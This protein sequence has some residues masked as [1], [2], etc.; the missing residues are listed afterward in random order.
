MKPPAPII[1]KLVHIHGPLKGTIQEFSGPEISIG[2]HPSCDIS[3]PKD[4]VVLSRRHARIIR[5]GNRFKIID[6]SINGTYV[7]KDRV[8]DAFLKNGDVITLT[9]GGPK[10]SFLTQVGE[11]IEMHTAPPSIS[12]APPAPPPPSNP[13]VDN[14]VSAPENP[15]TPV[16]SP[17][18][19]V[20]LSVPPTPDPVPS[21]QIQR[22]KAPLVIQ[23]GAI[24][25][26]F[27]ELPV[28]IGTDASCDLTL[29]H[30]SLAPKHVQFAFIDGQYMVKDLSGRDML[31]VNGR[32]V[33]SI[34]PIAPEDTIAFTPDG[35]AFQFMA[36][37]R[38]A[39]I[40]TTPDIEPAASDS[41]ETATKQ[42]TPKKKR[43]SLLKSIFS[44][45]P[46]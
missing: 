19:P 35:P 13:V 28:T 9:Q 18:D 31:R 20:P 33:T 4:L 6:S 22:V 30:P 14:T 25:Q 5:E 1:V 21:S 24:L 8:S 37:G 3:F 7:N 38:M 43:N 40:N 32:P 12:T 26:S 39:E 11:S 16:V 29:S 34:S 10:I 2:R 46:K 23:Y 45:E 15:A 41:M 44:R 42:E 36:G 17:A 27:S